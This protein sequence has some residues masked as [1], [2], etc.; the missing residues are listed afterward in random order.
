MI[1]ILAVLI[2][3][4]ATTAAAQFATSFKSSEVVPGIIMVEGADGFGGGNMA[5]LVG[6]DHVAMIDDGLDPLGE[7]LVAY[8]I[9][10]AGRPIDFMINTHVHGDHAGGNAHFA[11][12]G[13][14][15]FA[16]ENIRKRLLEDS[17]P[18]GGDGGLPIVTF[19][20]GVTFHL[21]GIEAQVIHF[22]MAHTDGDAAIYFPDVNVIHTGDIMFHGLFPFIDLDTGGTV[23]GYI[24]AQQ[25]ILSMADENT[26]I[27][28]G[29]GVLAT[30][31]DLQRT[32][33]MITDC[34]ARVKM[35]VDQGRTIEQVLE[36]DPL[37]VYHDDYNWNFITTERM[38]RTMYRSLT[39]G[40]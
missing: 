20:D 32:L 31:A 22:P 37:S 10:T 1:R 34:Q 19:G 9:E 40:E 3:L 11:D 6:K 24:E 36:S 16:H 12:S 14:V 5:L 21:N 4:A 30:K 29:H 2:T 18:A 23:K 35:L 7:M 25:K 15:V 17:E 27:I 8:V 26:K 39:E 33:M 28:P 13:T 38:T